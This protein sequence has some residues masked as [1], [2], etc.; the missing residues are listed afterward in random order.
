MK[1]ET[2]VQAKTREEALKLASVELAESVENLAAELIEEGKKGFLG[3]GATPSTFKV[4]YIFK[5]LEAAKSFATSLVENL[6]LNATVIVHDDGEG[7]ALMT[8][9]G[10][11]ASKLIGHHGD[12]LNA[13]QYLVNLAANK[14]E[15]D[16]RK[17]THVSV[18]IENYREKRESTLKELAEKMADKVKRT[19]K[20]VTLEPMDAYSRRI[21]HA[22]IQSIEGVSTNSVGSEGNR[23][24]VIYLEGSEKP[25][26]ESV[27]KS[28]KNRSGKKNSKGGNKHYSKKDSKSS[29]SS[30]SEYTPKRDPSKPRPQ[31]RKIEKAKDLDSYFEK[32]KE[33]SSSLNSNSTDSSN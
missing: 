10:E 28:E 18:D 22:T 5:P 12:T 24:V 16:A 7:E 8:I 14:K 21:I 9:S 29:K 31:P 1:K 15:D 3:M 13:F 17:Y 2:T 32:L 11:D 4:T 6:G 27:A 20:N 33:F 19:G 30:T 26:E 23:R 25:T